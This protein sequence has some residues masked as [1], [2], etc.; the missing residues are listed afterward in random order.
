MLIKKLPEKEF[1]ALFALMM[2]LTALSMDAIL[3]A[4]SVISSDLNIQNYQHTQW[5]ISVLVLGMA[6][7]EILFGPLSDAMGRKSTILLGVGIFIFGS[8]I[9]VFASS[10]PMLLIGRAVQGFGLAGPKIVSR[11]LIR[12]LY[13]GAAMARIL[14]YVMM[15]FI[16]VPMLAPIFGQFIMSLSSWRWMFVVLI[17]QALLASAWLVCRQVETLP[18][19]CRIPLNRS[20]LMKDAT[21]ILSRRDVIAYTLVSGCILGGLFLYLSIAQSLFQD[22]YQVG[23]EFT[24]YFALLAGFSGLSNFFN[25]R[26]VQKVGMMKCVVG[27]LSVLLCSSFLLF[28]ATLYSAGKPPFWLF[29]VLGAVMFSCL[30]M[31]FGNVSA[32]AME[33]LGKIAGLGASMIS[34]LSSL[35]A[36]VAATFVGQFYHFSVTPFAGGFVLFASLALLLLKV[37][38]QSSIVSIS[39]V[40]KPSILV[41]RDISR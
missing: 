37:A 36:I 25:G 24:L 8:L 5:I 33:P 21:F 17:V 6:C 41:R 27:A 34:S 13:C 31:V 22:V 38:K 19:E 32:M 7:G 10:L 35:T 29:M 30:G 3:P 15:V 9:T 20:R 40:Y 26:I 12:D 4:F 1:I 28:I 2:S 18:C 14:S 23:S 39:R 11:A 16:L